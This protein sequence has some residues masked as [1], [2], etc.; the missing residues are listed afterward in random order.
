MSRLSKKE[1]VG[2]LA[3]RTHASRSTVEAVLNA[4]QAEIEEACFSG[5]EVALP[6][7]GTFSVQDRAARTSRNPRT[8]EAV[9]V[10]A[11]RSLR[12]KPSKSQSRLSG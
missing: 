7:F 3:E 9:Q 8:G 5:K 6:K 4:F 1:L 2:A 12:F 10:P 11:R